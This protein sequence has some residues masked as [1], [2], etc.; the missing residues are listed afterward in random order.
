MVAAVDPAPGV[1]GGEPE[2]VAV[3][4]AP[5]P[6]VAGPVALVAGKAGVPVAAAA[7]AA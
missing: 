5:E 2:P 3:A 7:C 1:A 4:G 6:A